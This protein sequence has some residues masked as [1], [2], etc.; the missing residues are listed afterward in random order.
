L[1]RSRQRGRSA[2][3]EIIC[4]RGLTS[5]L[6]DGGKV[7]DI[8]LFGGWNVSM[9]RR[10]KILVSLLAALLICNSG[11]QLFS[12]YSGLREGERVKGLLLSSLQAHFPDRPFRAGVGF[13]G[14][15][16]VIEVL[17]TVSPEERSDIRAVLAAEK[18][19]GGLGAEIWLEFEADKN[20]EES[21]Q[22]I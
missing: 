3:P 21:R 11:L 22:R 13:E 18:A 10:T 20:A 8:S 14:P 7:L 5:I 1:A 16:V 15:S 12:I 6:I 17:G 9:P 2:P 19:K 4:L